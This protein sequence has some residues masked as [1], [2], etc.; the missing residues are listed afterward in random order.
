MYRYWCYGKYT[1]INSGVT[2]SVSLA[3]PKLVDCLTQSIYV[4]VPDIIIAIKFVQLKYN[5]VV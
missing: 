5:L 3:H 2:I 1:R 4:T